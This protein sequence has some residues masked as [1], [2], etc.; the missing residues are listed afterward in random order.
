MASG[1]NRCPVCGEQFFV[2]AAGWGY[3]Y[4]GV[5]TCSYHCMREM[6]RRDIS[7]TEEERN[8]IERM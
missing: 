5:Y 1:L 3:A 7:M 2:G 4:D 6:K 8:E